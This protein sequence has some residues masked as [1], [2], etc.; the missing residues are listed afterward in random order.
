MRD[1]G[2]RSVDHLARDAVEHRHFLERVQPIVEAFGAL[3]AFL[4]ARGRGAKNGP[5]R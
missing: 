3:A 4:R 2:K 1:A 5:R